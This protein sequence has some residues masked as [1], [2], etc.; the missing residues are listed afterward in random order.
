MEREVDRAAGGF[1]EESRLNRDR[2]IR[3]IGGECIVEL[4][5]GSPVIR[6]GV[7]AACVYG[8]HRGKLIAVKG[9]RNHQPAPVVPE[10]FDCTGVLL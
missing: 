4:F 7:A 8:F 10:A 2:V 1:S 9:C 3:I 6:T 5:V